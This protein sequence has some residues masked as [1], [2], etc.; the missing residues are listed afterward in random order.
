[1]SF[2]AGTPVLVVVG[3]AV[4]MSAGSTKIWFAALPG[5]LSVLDDPLCAAGG[6]RGPKTAGE[7]SGCLA[8][9][10]AGAAVV[11]DASL[12]RG[13]GDCVLAG[14]AVQVG[15]P[16]LGQLVADGRVHRGLLDGCGAV[17]LGCL[18]LR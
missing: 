3:A 15:D 16:G 17:P 10:G 2:M 7:N 11:P 6:Q 1:M 13:A 5:H 14:L 9:R 18:G 4:P 8:G 12:A